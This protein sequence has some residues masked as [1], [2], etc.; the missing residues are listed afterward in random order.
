MD[1]K[2]AMLGQLLGHNWARIN[3]DD[4]DPAI[5]I[6]YKGAAPSCTI[7]V[8]TSTGDIKSK[9][10]VLSSEAADPNFTLPGGGT[11]G[12]IDV[13][14]AAADTFAKVLAFINGL[15]DYEAFLVGAL[16]TDSTD[17]ALVTMAETQAKVT[18]GVA[19]KF[20][21][22][23]TDPKVLTNVAC[24]YTRTG[25]LGSF[26]DAGIG[27]NYFANDTNVR[28]SLLGWIAVNTFGSGTSKIMVYENDTKIWEQATAA[29]TVE[30]EKIFIPAKIQAA[31]GKLLKVRMVGSA[32]C[33]GSLACFF[34]TI[35][36]INPSY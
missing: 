5:V 18:N 3:V 21:T 17:N 10:G 24:E 25:L 36:Y 28:H 4:Q 26:T 30:Q 11:D 8:D 33:T 31:R 14:N 2:Q 13:S 9:I 23:A 16:P 35:N 6:R 29:T 7:E 1:Y 19:L 32:A 12:T 27:T 20:D 34:E 22:S 15:A